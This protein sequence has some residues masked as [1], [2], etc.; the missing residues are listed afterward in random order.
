MNPEEYIAFRSDPANDHTTDGMWCGQRVP[1]INMSILLS[2]KAEH[3]EKLALIL[4]KR[5]SLYADVLIQIDQGLL[6]K[7]KSGDPRSVELVWARFENWSPKI[8]EQA[9]K[10]GLGRNKTLADL[11][12][13]L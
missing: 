2:W 13:E 4:E 5:R 6:A 3:P 8:E 11:M 1:S 9:A 7:A 12:G 10:Q